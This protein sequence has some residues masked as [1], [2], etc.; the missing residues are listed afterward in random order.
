[1]TTLKARIAAMDAEAVSPYKHKNA[2][3]KCPQCYAE[4][5]KGGRIPSK[6]PPVFV[7]DFSGPCPD[8]GHALSNPGICI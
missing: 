3:K 2:R 4:W 6:E 8:C 5:I 7:Y 1:M